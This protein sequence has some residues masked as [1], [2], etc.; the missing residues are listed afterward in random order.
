MEETTMPRILI[1]IIDTVTNDIVGPVQVYGHP[2][3]AIRMFSDVALDERTSIH[4]HIKDHILVSLGTLTDELT[5][6]ANRVTL[7][8][9]E[10]WLA[11]QAPKENE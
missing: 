6:E 3:P 4:Q 5:V 9:G 2:A 7:I 8:T 10:Q 1:A 11:A